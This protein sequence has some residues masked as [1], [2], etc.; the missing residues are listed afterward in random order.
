MK[1]Q[2]NMITINIS[3]RINVPPTVA[4]DLAINFLDEYP[5]QDINNV[6]EFDGLVTF[7]L[8]YF[9]NFDDGLIMT[10]QLA[11]EFESWYKDQ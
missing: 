11:E 7:H 6:T 9:V 10:V 2:T 1:N 8:N 5:R 3:S 4:R